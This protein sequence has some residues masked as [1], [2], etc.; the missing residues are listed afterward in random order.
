M[1]T[2]PSFILLVLCLLFAQTT[3]AQVGI[4]T[5]NPNA[6]AV[7]DLRSPTNNQGLLVPRLSTAQRTATAFIS[8][9]TAAEKGL[10]VFDT[11]INKFCFWTGTAWI[12]IEDSTGTDSQTLGFNPSTGTLTISGGNAISINGA[13][14]GGNAGG[15]LIGTYPNPTLNNN[16][17]TSAKLADGTVAT[18]DVADG[19]ITNVK[20]ANGVAVNKLTAGTNGQILATNAGVPTWTT[21]SFGTITNIATGTGLSGGPITNTGTISLANTAVTAGTY[22]TATQVP[23]FTVDAQGRITNAGNLTITGVAPGGAA[24]GDLAGTYPNP[25]IA[26]TSGNNIAAAINNTGTTN[27]INTNRLNTAVVLETE[28]PAAGDISGTYGTGFQIGSGTVTTTEIADLTIATTD[29]AANAVTDAKIAS[30]IT[31]SKITPSATNNQI[32]TTIA[33]VATWANAPSPTGAAAGDLAGTYPNPTIATTS[34]NNIAA[35]INNTGTTNT[36]NTNR[37]NAAVVLETE[38]PAAGDISG[39]YGTGFQIGSGTVTTTEIAD[40]TIATT[41]LAANAVTDAKIASGITASKITPSATNNQILTTIAGVAT[42]ANAPSPTGTAAGDLAGTYPNPTIATTSG[43]NIAAAINNTGTTNT[44][45][46]NRLNAAVVLETENPAAGDISGTYGTG[47]QI[48]SG[49]VTT[50][51]IAD[52]TIATTDLAANAVTDAKIANGIAVSKLTPTTI[53]NAMLTTVA[54]VV[55]WAAAPTASGTAGGDLSGTYPNPTVDGLQGRPI[56]ATAPT[57]GQV[58]EWNGTAWAPA[59]DDSGGG[60]ISG[61]G[62]INQVT[63]WT[64]TSAING[65]NNMVYDNKNGYLGLATTAPK[66]NLHVNGSQYVKSDVVD[67]LNGNYTVGNTEYF[68]IVLASGSQRITLPPIANSDGRILI[69]KTKS[70]EGFDL[71]PF[72]PKDE[73]IEGATGIKMA[74]N[75][76]DISSLTL[77]CNAE[78]KQWFVVSFIR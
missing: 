15:D 8:S 42:W 75:A 72:D 13:I 10:L 23:N 16:V 76:K 20:I 51:E 37:L 29:L 33:G 35:A 31:A 47:F 63:Y 5:E 12:V 65:D 60:G 45:N 52:L 25:T 30:G 26:T 3:Q 32:L 69:I 49:T 55:T 68:M 62:V 7:L 77:V 18:I 56:A 34:G 1:K 14:P 78:A 22:G 39:T 48:G 71:V 53:P 41:D 59:T 57:T 61:S 36:I 24:A 28:N 74:D 17:V 66:G 43:N 4:G 19:A 46:T 2:L 11:D 54:G 38:N 73:R 21:P 9:L 67:L 50:T 58:L 64:G 40:L 44:I 70:I 6:K 27:T